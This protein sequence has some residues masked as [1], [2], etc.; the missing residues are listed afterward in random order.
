MLLRMSGTLADIGIRFNL[1]EVKGPL[2]KELQAT[3][4]ADDIS[5]NIY[6]SN[7]EALRAL[8][9]PHGDSGEQH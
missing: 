6:F 9:E 1:S 8:T 2:L 7:D 4:L 3:G 5:G